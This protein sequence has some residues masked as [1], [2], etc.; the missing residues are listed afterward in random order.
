M[1]GEAHGGILT[2]EGWGHLQAVADAM[3]DEFSDDL[4]LLRTEGHFVDT[5]MIDDLPRAFLPRY[6]YD[7]AKRIFACF[8]TVLWKVFAP[9]PFELACVAEEMLLHG[10]LRRATSETGDGGIAEGLDEFVDVAFQDTGFLYL[11]DPR[12]DGIQDS[13]EGQYLRVAFLRFEEWFAP[14]DNVPYVHPYALGRDVEPPRRG[15][16]T[17]MTRAMR[18]P[19]RPGETTSGIPTP[20]AERPGG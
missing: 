13:P 2:R 1:I 19:R 4:G 20:G 7:F 15:T 17:T 16:T 11:F 9:E 5:S 6:D 14:F 10:L 8:N 18:G 3:F 12:F